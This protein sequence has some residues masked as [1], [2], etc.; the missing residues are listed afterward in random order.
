MTTAGGARR[1]IDPG[2]HAGV[3]TRLSASLRSGVTP[4]WHRRGHRALGLASLLHARVERG[5]AASLVLRRRYG[6]GPR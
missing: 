3:E 6:W 5:R 4:P 1:G 2:L